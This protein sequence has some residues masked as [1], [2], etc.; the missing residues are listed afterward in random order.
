M[1][2]S[3]DIDTKHFNSPLGALMIEFVKLKR[4]CGSK[5]I[6]EYH[7][8]RR[9]D[10]FLCEH[11][12]KSAMLSKELVDG[13]IALHYGEATRSQQ[14]RI[15]VA[16]L[17]AQF[18]VRREID[19]YV[20]PKGAG[21][22]VSWRSFSPYIFSHEQIDRLIELLDNAPPVRIAPFKHIVEKEL[23]RVI[24]CCG[25]RASEAAHLKISDADLESG[26]LSIKQGKFRKDRLIPLPE[27]LTKRLR[28][29]VRLIPLVKGLDS[30]F[31]PNRLG[32]HYSPLT[33]YLMFRDLLWKL[34]IP[35]GGRGKGP[36]LHDLRHSFA[37]HRL[38]QWIKGHADVNAKLPLL[39]AYL[40]HVGIAGTQRYLRLT[41]ASFPEIASPLNEQFKHLLKGGSKNEAH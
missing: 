36:R 26:V 29:Y 23:F 32:R 33:L 18:L 22:R 40:G 17:F 5:Y 16:K 3:Q 8:L 4:S 41:A 31:F 34:R 1:Y 24:Y 20:L 19:A 38:E 12:L 9:F 28:A 7:H 14:S 11:G 30:P 10:R 35:H 6:C 27:S 25:L 2:L 13:W 37:V 15:T 39:S 21:G